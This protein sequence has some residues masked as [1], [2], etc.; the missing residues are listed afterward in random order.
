MYIDNI[1]RIVLC[2]TCCFLYM[3]NRYKYSDDL[4]SDFVSSV[5]VKEG[6]ENP[7]LFQGD[8]SALL[9][10]LENKYGNSRPGQPEIF[11]D[12]KYALR[13]CLKERRM[14]AC[15]YIYS[16]MNMHEEAVALALQV[17]F[18]KHNVTS[19]FNNTLKDI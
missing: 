7:V 16:S 5:A 15:V 9:Q 1:A 19:S 12:P 11:Y 6:C 3:L 18:L 13:L 2:I 14:R 8:E 4:M 10:F 17:H